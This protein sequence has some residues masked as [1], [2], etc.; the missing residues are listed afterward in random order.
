MI[1]IV[2]LS[3]PFSGAGRRKWCKGDGHGHIKHFKQTRKIVYLIAMASLVNN[4][5]SYLDFGMRAKWSREKKNRSIKSSTTITI[6]DNNSVRAHTY[7]R[8]VTTF[9]FIS[10]VC[11]CVCVCVRAYFQY[12][13]RNVTIVFDW[14]DIHACV[15]YVCAII[16]RK[17]WHW[18]IVIQTDQKPL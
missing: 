10:Y 6:N 7:I 5:L 12:Y 2:S 15:V 11:V 3:F 16:S 1:L 4:F 13:Y 17:W 8:D 14:Q 18:L 9:A